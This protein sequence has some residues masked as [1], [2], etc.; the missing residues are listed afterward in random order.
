MMRELEDIDKHKCYILFVA[1]HTLLEK[2]RLFIIKMDPWIRAESKS[3]EFGVL[4]CFETCDF[5]LPNERLSDLKKVDLLLQFD[6]QKKMQMSL[7]M[8]YES[9]LWAVP[10]TTMN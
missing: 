8:Q 7:I 9:S 6:E 3:S 4:D 5:N 2:N 10:L 1:Q